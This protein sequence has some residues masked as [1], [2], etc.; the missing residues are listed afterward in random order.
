[1]RVTKLWL[2]IVL[3]LAG[4]AASWAQQ[5]WVQIEAQPTLA[6]AEARARAYA[7]AFPNVAGFAMSTG[8]YA[9]ALGPYATAEE[10][11]AQLQVLKGERLIPSDSYLAD[12][13]RFLRQF[14]PVG[15][16]IPAPVPA[17]EP[18]TGAATQPGSGDAVTELPAALPD[19]T[20]DEARRSEALLTGAERMDLQRALLWFGHYQG[21]IDGAFGAGTRRSMAAWQSAEGLEPTGVLTTAQRS[22]LLS[23]YGTESAAIGLRPVSEDEAGIDITLP[24]ALVEFDRYQAPFVHY[25]EKAGSGYRVLLISQSG[26]RTALSGLYDLMQTLEIVPTEGER[27]LDSTSFVLTGRNPGI[28]SY[29]LAK[30]DGGV[31]K[32]FTLVWPAGDEARAARVLEAMRTSFRAVGTHALDGSVATPL[33][34]SR[35]D[36]VAGL[37]VRRPTM[38]R[39]GFYVDPTGRVAT[40][41]E[42]VQGCGR[43]TI[44]G[45]IEMTVAAKD[46][47]TGV[48]ILSPASALAPVGVARFQDGA[49]PVGSEVAVAGYSYPDTLSE[50]VLTFGTLADTR[51][52]SGDERRQRLQIRTLDGDAGG[53]VLDATGRV[54]GMLLPNTP[55]DGRILPEDVRFAIDAATLSSALG[56]A[57]A[58]EVTAGAQ[59]AIA[60]E[61]IARIGRDMTVQVSCWQ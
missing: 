34:V 42:V 37:A 35:P 18:E 48:A 38:S 17:G 43:I 44:D 4:A 2:G 21:A 36:L 46:D 45:G 7:N 39:S 26:D 55:V 16:A 27:Q 8:W 57:P 3:W 41:S 56:S 1:M 33:A 58:G 6:E 61:D 52:L 40:T 51:D 25:R 13:G 11:A 15:G 53:P 31:I 19:E 5:S 49:M 12:G 24:L 29:T 23:G 9:I 32:G 60:A 10:A 20:P 22:R 54:I 47:L 28:H 50:P 14:W 59:G 30:L